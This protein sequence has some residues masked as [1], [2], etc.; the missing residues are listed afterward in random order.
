MKWINYVLHFKSSKVLFCQVKHTQPHT[1]CLVVRHID[2]YTILD[3]MQK[4]SFHKACE[5]RVY[6]CIK[7]SAALHLYVIC[8]SS[9]LFHIYNLIFWI[10][11]NLF[12]TSKKSIL[13]RIF[14]NLVNKPVCHFIRVVLHF[15]CLNVKQNFL[16]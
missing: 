16:F 6:E 1:N 13:F 14:M 11:S 8:F 10:E 2:A 3:T 9:F 15:Y 5:N 7:L 12:I 4:I